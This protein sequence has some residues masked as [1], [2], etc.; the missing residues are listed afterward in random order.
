MTAGKFIFSIIL[1]L[2]ITVFAF[3]TSAPTLAITPPSFPSCTNPEGQ[4]IAQYSTGTHGVPGSLAEY[5]GSDAVYRVSDDKLIQCLCTENG[6]GTQTN[7]WKISSISESDVNV[8]K[9]LG[10]IF[11]PSG[12]VWGLTDDSYMAFNSTFS[13]KT[14]ATTTSSGGGGGESESGGGQGGPSISPGEVLGLA[15]TGGIAPLYG[16]LVIG[17][18]SL[19]LGLLLRRRK[20]N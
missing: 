5:R 19:L 12:S 3:L 10:W 16:L 11:I 18:T 17:S 14:T 2:F 9:S 20:K 1:Y 13:C 7:W 15:T 6:D 8:L 4:I